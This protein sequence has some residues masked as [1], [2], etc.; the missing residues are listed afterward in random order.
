VLAICGSVTAEEGDFLVSSPRQ[1]SQWCPPLGGDAAPPVQPAWRSGGLFFGAGRCVTGPSA[2][3]D[4]FPDLRV[5]EVFRWSHRVL[6]KPNDLRVRGSSRE[7]PGSGEAQRPSGP[8]VE[9]GAIR[10]GGS[11]RVTLRGG[12]AGARSRR[13]APL[14]C[15]ARDRRFFGIAGRRNP[16]L[17]DGRCAHGPLGPAAGTMLLGARGRVNGLLVPDRLSVLWV[18]GVSRVHPVRGG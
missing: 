7:P 14:E 13:C 8:R 10:P 12:S 5:R 4:D 11:E 1:G 17:R 15:H 9:S 6:A 16:V 2:P 18:G 3:S